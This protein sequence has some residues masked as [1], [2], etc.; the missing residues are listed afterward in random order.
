M[1]I[2]NIKFNLKIFLIDKAH[3]E[4]IEK[5]ND[6]IIEIIRD[7]H[8]KHIHAQNDDLAMVKPSLASYENDD[9]KFYSY[10]YNQPKKQN[11]W[12]LYLPNELTKDN[13]FDILEFSFVLFVVYNQSI[14]CVIGGSGANVIKNILM[15]ISV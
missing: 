5:N 8:K 1:A 3:Y 6:E 7:N 10:C 12:K 13:N 11:Y 2:E 4:F 14:Y 15:Y 9:Y